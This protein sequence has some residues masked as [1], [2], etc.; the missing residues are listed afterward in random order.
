MIIERKLHKGILAT[1]NIYIKD[2]KIKK[3]KYLIEFIGRRR[4]RRKEK[5]I[6]SMYTIFYTGCMYT[7]YHNNCELCKENMRIFFCLC[8]NNILLDV[9]I[10]I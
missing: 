3:K 7:I 4:T 10:Y 6:K 2:T 8:L 9:S 1:C 5:L